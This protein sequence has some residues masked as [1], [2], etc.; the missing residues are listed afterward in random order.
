MVLKKSLG[1]G[2]VRELEVGT[3]VLFMFY[4]VVAIGYV[5][6]SSP[7]HPFRHWVSCSSY[8]SRG[9][10]FG[11]SCLCYTYTMWSS[12]FPYYCHDSWQA[13]VQQC[14]LKFTKDNLG[15]IHYLLHK[16]Q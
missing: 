14:E 11:R 7:T 1:C 5:T 4:F 6:F 10:P 3:N 9:Q 13:D 8:S 16:Q 2:F 12:S 15:K